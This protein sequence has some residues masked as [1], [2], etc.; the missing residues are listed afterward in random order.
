MTVSAVLGDSNPVEGCPENP[1]T[2]EWDD[3]GQ[4]FQANKLLFILN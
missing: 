4:I 2:H 3:E 1:E